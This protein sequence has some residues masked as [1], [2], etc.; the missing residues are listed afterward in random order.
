MP[1][2]ETL[3]HWFGDPGYDRAAREERD[4]MCE[5]GHVLL[6]HVHHPGRVGS[7]LHGN[8]DCK[9][10]DFRAKEEDNAE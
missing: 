10:L 7:C 8:G 4:D 9:C 6:N 1:D 2:R 3:D 5:C